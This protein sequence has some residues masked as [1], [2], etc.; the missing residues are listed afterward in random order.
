MKEIG[1]DQY[2]QLFLEGVPLIDVRSEIEFEEGSFPDSIN[3]PILRT[4]ERVRVGTV[5]KHQGRQVAVQLGHEIISG[6]L[7]EQRIQSWIEFIQKNPQAVLTCFR[8]GLRSQIAQQW[9][10]DHS[11]AIPRVQGGT[12]ALRNFLMQQ[13]TI[14][15]PRAN[16]LLIS[17]A[18]GAGKTRFLSEPPSNSLDLEK[19]ARHR[20]SSFG[21]HLQPQ[22]SQV[23]FENQISIE[24]MRRKGGVL[25]VEDESRMIGQRVIPEV[26]FNQM[27][28][29]PALLIE[30]NLKARAQN[31][32]QDYVADNPL[33]EIPGEKAELG[34]KNFKTSFQQIAKKLGG[35]RTDEVLKDLENARKIFQSSGDLTPNLVWIQKVIDWYYDPLYFRS[36]EKRNIPWIFRGSYSEGLEFI[37]TWSEVPMS[38]SMTTDT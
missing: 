13:M 35:L 7:R 11:F 29:S 28:T 30:E 15:T 21:A 31:T 16:F 20:G 33:F 12:K 2:L 23:L 14:L 25:L 22:P 5:Y 19:L 10:L 6:S 38:R 3:L 24:L 27:R 32:Y 1:A 18:T 4:L 26:L 37:R 36:L 8:G 9:C 34:F 17:G